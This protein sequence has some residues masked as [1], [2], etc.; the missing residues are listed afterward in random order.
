MRRASKGSAR[1]RSEQENGVAARPLARW[2]APALFFI[3]RFAACDDA[4]QVDGHTLAHED[5]D[6]PHY[7]RRWG[8]GCARYET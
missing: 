2:G 6:Q 4:H 7:P 8:I 3:F 1:T 5:E